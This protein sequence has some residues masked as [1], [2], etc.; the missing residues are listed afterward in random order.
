[1][2]VTQNLLQG[3]AI[4]VNNRNIRVAKNNMKVTDLQFK[5]Q[6]IT[7]VSAVL[8]LYWDLVSFNEDMRIKQQALETAQ[9]L[10]D[11]NKT[12]GGSGHA[13]GH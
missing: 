9:K 2:Y 8:N 6:V 12:A 7:T 10:F 11:D 5:R 1:M 13:A 4:G 3:C